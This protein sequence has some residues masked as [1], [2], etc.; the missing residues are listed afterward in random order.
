LNPIFQSKLFWSGIAIVFLLPPLYQI[1]PVRVDV[2]KEHS[3]PYTFWIT[4]APFDASKDKYA[5]FHP[6]VKNNY[7]E[8]V[9][10]L[11]K[12]VG[13]SEG[14]MLNTSTDGNYFCDGKYLGKAVVLDKNGVFVEHYKFNGVI[15]KDNFF[16]MGTH[17]HSYD[18]RY[19][20]FVRKDQIE[21]GAK[22]LW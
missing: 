19:F 10:Y 13:C 1:L 16:M 3:L 14:H 15:P 7:T 12:E 11:L 8:K 9:S 6:T 20:G 2:T 4:K 21:R 18:S 22:P 5:M 17:P